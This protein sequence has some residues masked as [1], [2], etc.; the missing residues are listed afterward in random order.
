MFDINQQF[1]FGSLHIRMIDEVRLCKP[2]PMSGIVLAQMTRSSTLG[3]MLGTTPAAAA[4][5]DRVCR[6]VA[7]RV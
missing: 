6:G 7:R 5:G 1:R 3:K 4:A 2:M